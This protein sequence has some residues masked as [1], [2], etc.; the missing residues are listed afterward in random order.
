MAQKIEISKQDPNI[1]SP[2]NL[3]FIGDSVYE[4]VIRNRVLSEHNTNLKELNTLSQTLT[5]AKTQNRIIRALEKYLTDEEMKIYKRGRNAKSVSTPKSCSVSEYRHATG[6]EALIGYLYLKDDISR[7]VELID[8][9]I[10]EVE[11]ND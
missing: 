7:I 6:F 11:Q 4:L 9:G 5:K 1:V 2:L 10:K 8:I 3:A